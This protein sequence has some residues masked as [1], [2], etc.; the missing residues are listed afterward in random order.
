LEGVRIM[1]NCIKKFFNDRKI[2]CKNCKSWVPADFCLKLDGISWKY[3]DA[4]KCKYF[5]KKE[6]MK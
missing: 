5:R 2:T 4:K 1:W 3:T 6:V